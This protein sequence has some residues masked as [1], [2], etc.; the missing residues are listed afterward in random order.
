MAPRTRPKNKVAHPAAPVM[1]NAAKQKAGIKVKPLPKRVTMS[2]KVRWL[3][4][5]IA[6]MENPDEGMPSREP[7]VCIPES[8]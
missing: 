3:E 5:K 2:D 4:A 8:Y 6:G 7:L 1:T